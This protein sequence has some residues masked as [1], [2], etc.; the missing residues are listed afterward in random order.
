M[1]SSLCMFSQNIWHY[2][3]GCFRRLVL[4]QSLQASKLAEG[5]VIPESYRNVA[6]MQFFVF[7]LLKNIYWDL[8][9]VISPTF[10][11]RWW[12][13]V[14]NY[15]LYMLRAQRESS[16]RWVQQNHTPWVLAYSSQRSHQ[17]NRFWVVPQWQ[18]MRNCYRTDLAR[19][20][21]T[22]AKV[23]A[24]PE[25]TSLYCIANMPL[26]GNTVVIHG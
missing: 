22:I 14:G 15:L 26:G 17:D 13:L 24:P 6:E 18:Q 8:Y 12:Q 7:F 5:E 9:F 21:L 10:F 3:M 23:Q 20:F 25:T 11:D 1:L 2:W 16:Q 19:A 4:A